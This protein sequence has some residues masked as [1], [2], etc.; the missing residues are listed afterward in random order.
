[1]RPVT[2]RSEQAQI[3]AIIQA[4]LRAAATARTIFDALDVTGSALRSIQD[5]AQRPVSQ[6]AMG[7][8]N[9]ATY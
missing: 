4:A 9:K 1:M 7:Q 8:A 2:V 3:H 5:L 6:R